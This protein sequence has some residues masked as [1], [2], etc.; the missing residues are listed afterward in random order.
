MRTPRACFAFVAVLALSDLAVAQDTTRVSVDSA[1]VEG[2]GASGAS[3]S[4][5]SV[6]SDGNVVAFY[7]F[8]TNLVP[9]DTNAKADVFVHDRSTGLTER[10]SVDSA[11]AE[12]NENST[13]ATISADG[14]FVVFASAATNLVAGDTNGYWDIFVHD[15][16]TG[17]TERVSVDSA[18]AEANWG[19]GYDGDGLS[20]SADGRWVAFSSRASNLVA[21][22]TNGIRDV[23]VRDRSAGTTERVTVDSSG[24]Q[25]KWGGRCGAISADGN[26]VAFYSASPDLVAS[27]TN[28]QADAFVHDRTTGITE[29]V[30]VDS[31]GAEANKGS[32]H[33]RIAISPDGNIVA[34]VSAATNLVAGDTNGWLDIFVRDRS[35]GTTERVSVDSSGIEGNMNSWGPTIS[36]DARFVG[37]VS[38]ASN[39][40]PGDTNGWSDVFVRDRTAGITERV[41]VDASGGEVTPSSYDASISADGEV[42]VFASYSDDLVPGDNNNNDDIFARDRCDAYWSS[43]GDG[44][45]GT[46]G[47]P[48]LTC[49]TDPVLGT[50]VTVDLSNSSGSS[51]IG[52]L[53]IGFDR[54]QLHSSWGGDLLVI[55]FI[56]MLVDIPAGGLSVSGDLPDD[57]ALCGVKIDLQAFEVDSGAAHG[58]SFTR[59][60]ELVLGR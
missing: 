17:V 60:L 57:E 35:A 37:F 29:R 11:G 56:T 36:A 32:D 15:R 33:S 21:G 38:A 28:G 44:F 42:V 45:P 34:F 24:A 39:L 41:S 13:F 16:S 6:S 9:G 4:L 52:L 8:A 55:P 46:N 2:N 23:F 54:A 12:A 19:S 22:D 20:I 18:G 3:G 1:G 59:G 14:G 40:V 7:S 31:A 30:S 48:S 10:V 53:F 49:P 47:V 58:V 43:Y 26:V 50:T 27:D 25:A 5:G 51:T